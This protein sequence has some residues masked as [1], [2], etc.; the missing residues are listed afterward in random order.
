MK[1]LIVD[2]E[3][4][5]RDELEYL[6]TQNQVVTKVQQADSISAAITQ[7]VAMPMDLVFLD[8]SLSNENGFDL[9]DKLHQ[10]ATP[11]LVVFATAYDQYAVRAFNIDAIDYVLKPFE[12]RRIDQALAKAATALQTRSVDQRETNLTPTPMANA[13]ISITEDEKTRVLKQRD[14]LAGFV[15]NGELVII[16]ATQRIGAHQTLSWLL[17]RLAP[18]QFMQI[19]RSMVVNVNAVSEVEPWFNH[20][21][22]ITLTN[23]DKMPVSRSFVKEMKQRLN[24]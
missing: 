21:Y 22:Q 10:L 16:T 13:V 14:I 20:T 6:L 19:H 23:G 9:A 5:A 3:P 24:M 7:L 1:V 8:I 18:E 12:Q 11:P 17:T 2:D 15:E 4:L